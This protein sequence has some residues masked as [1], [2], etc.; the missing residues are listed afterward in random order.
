MTVF[1]FFPSR[2]LLLKIKKRWSLKTAMLII[3]FPIA[4]NDTLMAFIIM[5]LSF[6][7]LIKLQFN[8]SFDGHNCMAL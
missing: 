5:E 7:R 4:N 1:S 3:I 8:L 6:L 2:N